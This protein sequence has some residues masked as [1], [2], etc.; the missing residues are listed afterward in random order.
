MKSVL[1]LFQFNIKKELQSLLLWIATFVFAVLLI[2]GQMVYIRHF[3]L[4]DENDYDQIKTRRVADVSIPLHDSDRINYYIE[5][6]TK[7]LETSA[8]VSKSEVNTIGEEL[9]ELLSQQAELSIQNVMGA[10]GILK[11]RHQLLNQWSDYT[12]QNEYNFS[13]LKEVNYKELRAYINSTGVSFNEAFSR[14]YAQM[15]AMISCIAFSIYFSFL[16]SSEMNN[17]TIDTLRIV[18][19]NKKAMYLVKYIAGL[20]ACSIAIIMVTTVVYILVLCCNPGTNLDMLKSLARWLV[21]YTLPTIMFI[22][23]ATAMISIVTKSGFVGLP[24]GLIFIFLSTITMSTSNGDIEQN[25]FLSPLVMNTLPYYSQLTSDYCGNLLLSRLFWLMFSFVFLFI[26]CGIWDKIYARKQKENRAIT[27]EISIQKNQSKTR[28]TS[29]IQY[30]AM[31]ALSPVA[32]LCAVVF[33]IAPLFLNHFSSISEIGPTI[34]SNVGWAA[35]LLFSRLLSLEYTNDTFDVL[36]VTR[37]KK[38]KIVLVRCLLAG[39]FLIFAEVLVFFVALCMISDYTLETF[40]VCFIQSLQ[41]FITNTFFWGVLSMCI[42][43]ILQKTWAGLCIATFIHLLFLSVAERQSVFNPYVYK[44]YYS[45]SEGGQTTFILS[46]IIYILLTC[47][48]IIYAS[49][50]LEGYW[51]KK[52]R[53]ARCNTK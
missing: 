16:F 44:V 32:I 37:I 24:I 38:I 47:M 23:S 35:I 2:S 33:V 7:V 29:F 34:L 10:I 31:I 52:Y 51:R 53:L 40:A 36:Y 49:Q 11:E 21:I 1:P 41:A 15:A 27:T 46:S 19:L 26:A 42:S 45:F 50:L 9:R 39:A 14:Q 25:M 18:R 20:I 48:I 28:K 8:W 5:R 12:F 43:A 6:V 17:S 30:N 13:N 22:S 4:Q 3:K